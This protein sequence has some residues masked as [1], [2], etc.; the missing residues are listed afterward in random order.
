MQPDNLERLYELLAKLENGLGGRVPLGNGPGG[1]RWA[2]RGVYFIFEPGE[3]RGANPDNLRV[4]RVGTHGLKRGSESTLQGRLRAHAGQANGGGNH[5]GS[6]FR[7]HTG[8]TL[9]DR[10]GRAHDLPEWGAGH[11]APREVRMAERGWERRV[12]EYLRTMS[13][14]WVAVPDEPGPDSERGLSERNSIALLSS[15]GRS[16][17][18]PSAGWLGHRSRAQAIRDSGLWNVNH[19]GYDYDPEFLEVLAD[20]V[21]TMLRVP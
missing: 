16:V 20:H 14:P 4:V 7:L 6:V 18:P 8:A 5:R 12:S 11:S 15:V 2:E 9:L 13:L 17:D 1:I 3:C 19:V 10:E 21:R